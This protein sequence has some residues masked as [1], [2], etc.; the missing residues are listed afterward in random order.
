MPYIDKE[1]RTGFD[2]LVKEMNSRIKTEGQLNYV[3]TKL[4][5]GFVNNFGKKYKTFNT[6]IGAI[7]CAKQEFYR[8]FIAPYE[9]EKIKTNGDL[10]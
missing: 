1:E 5:M 10:D 2:F 6:I 8:R 9:D 7:E 3:I 4:L